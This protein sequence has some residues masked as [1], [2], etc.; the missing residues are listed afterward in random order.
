MRVLFGSWR[1][2]R[3][4]LALTTAFTAL[5]VACAAPVL[6]ATPLA[7]RSD[8]HRARPPW[9]PLAH[10]ALFSGDGFDLC[11][12]PPLS[13]LQAWWGT[14]GYQ[15]LG[16]YIGGINWNC[17]T[18]D[19]TRDWVRAAD[20]IGWRLVPI[21][22]GRQAPCVR[23][24]KLAVMDPKTVQAQAAAAARDAVALAT[25]LG[26][27]RGS[28]IYLDLE[29]YRRGDVT[30]A[31]TALTYVGTFTRL[32]HAHGYLAGIYSSA[33]S[34]IKDL[35]AAPGDSPPDAVWIGRWDDTRTLT[36]PAL[37]DLLWGSHRRIKQYTNALKETHGGA[38]L[39]VDKDVIDGPVARV[40]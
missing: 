7:A 14:S 25:S 35:A 12:A 3:R 23:Q 29:A 24:R 6:A 32:L 10:P 19:L 18:S 38:S 13:T 26:L 20:R 39:V 31:G 33:G 5:L 4:A 17:G 16:L 8:F 9:N 11:K 15:A 36:D 21:Y 22:V 40:G 37:P 1:A 2:R 30:C 34:G 27:A 28:A